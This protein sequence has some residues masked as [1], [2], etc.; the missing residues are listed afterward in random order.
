M[1]EEISK[2]E[3][4]KTPEKPKRNKII[5]V[6]VGLVVVCCCLVLA[7]GASGDSAEDGESVAT[8]EVQEQIVASEETAVIEV[9][10][11]EEV[12]PTST[13]MPTDIPATPEPTN[14]PGPTNTPTATPLPTNT[15][16]PEALL[17]ALII[18]AVGSNN[19][20]VEAVSN[21]S[22]VDGVINVEWAINDNLTVDMIK[23]GAK[24]D[25]VDILKAVEASGLD[26]SMVNITGTFSMIDSFGNA[27]EMPV[28]R[29]SYTS[30][31]IAQINWARFLFANVYIIA[32]SVNL[33]PEFQED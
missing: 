21:V 28:V 18:D 14:T 24:L 5:V 8:V 30:D 22:I 26:Y 10:E 13:A 7:I 23:G 3:V 4:T 32:D 16:E 31:T 20:D 6:A 27:E 2:D 33:H 25:I 29:A 17:E 15:P 12:T 9:K 11:T 19:R 1:N